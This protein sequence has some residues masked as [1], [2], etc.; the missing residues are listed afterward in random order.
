MKRI[1]PISMSTLWLLLFV[2]RSLAMGEPPGIVEMTNKADLICCGVYA[3]VQIIDR[4]QISATNCY[5]RLASEVAVDH[6]IKGNIGTNA[7]ILMPC[8]RSKRMISKDE[9]EYLKRACLDDAPR[10][11]SHRMMWFLVRS[12]SVSSNLYWR[13]PG[14]NSELSLARKPSEK[15]NHDDGVDLSI[16]TELRNT[17]GSTT[18][19]STRRAL[20]SLLDTWN[21]DRQRASSTSSTNSQEVIREP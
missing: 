8:S 21:T 2:H 6:L 16:E 9:E 18:S 14:I 19:E 11:K 1:S 7:T 3:G 20:Q 10:L 13:I 17:I 15:R 4:E 5:G 12:D